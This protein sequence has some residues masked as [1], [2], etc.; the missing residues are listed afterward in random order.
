MWKRGR[1]R[2]LVLVLATGLGAMMSVP[3][4]SHADETGKHPFVLHMSED[5]DEVT[6]TLLGQEIQ[7]LNRK[8]D[9]V[10]LVVSPN[11]QNAEVRELTYRI[12]GEGVELTGEMDDSPD[13][14]RSICAGCRS[15]DELSVRWL[16]NG[17]LVKTL[18]HEKSGVYPRLEVVRCNAEVGSEFFIVPRAAGDNRLSEAL[19]LEQDLY[20][21]VGEWRSSRFR[22][23]E[24]EIVEKPERDVVGGETGYYFRVPNWSP[25]TLLAERCTA[26][27]SASRS[28]QLL[29]RPSQRDWDDRHRSKLYV[30][31]AG[32]GSP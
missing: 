27:G 6:R 17:L 31:P 7:E 4:T 3:P 22:Y 20:F 11:P 19:P 16:L 13:P 5:S 26:T 32:G 2:A 25:S 28:V 23:P 21:L 1:G 8:L 18:F 12:T 14:V 24:I 30:N 29:T 10:T 15:I 9:Y